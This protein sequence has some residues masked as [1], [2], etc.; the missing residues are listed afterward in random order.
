MPLRKKTTSRSVQYAMGVNDDRAKQ[1]VK[2]ARSAKK[3]RKAIQTSR[4]IVQ[5]T[6]DPK[7]GKG[8]QAIEPAKYQESGV[9]GKTTTRKQRRQLISGSRQLRSK[10]NTIKKQ[11]EKEVKKTKKQ[12]E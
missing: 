9:I 2:D 8:G 7:T 10:L 4:E 1:N 6:Q 3:T 11:K 5:S 12:K